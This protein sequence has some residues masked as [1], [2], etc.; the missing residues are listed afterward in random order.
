MVVK[1][2]TLYVK[3]EQVNA[4]IDATRENQRNSLQEK[5]ISVFDFY[6][7][8]DDPTQFILYEVYL[9]AEAVD[10]HMT[11]AHYKKWSETV[12]PMYAKPRDRA[13]YVD[14][15]RLD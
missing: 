15:A 1:V 3:R 13:I 2:V 9:T 10:A 5:G 14:V 6:Q 7:S 4:F 11:T 8:Q 12:P